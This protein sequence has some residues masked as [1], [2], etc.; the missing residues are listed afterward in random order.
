MIDSII[1]ILLLLAISSLGS[2]IYFYGTRPVPGTR[3]RR[4]F[5]TLWTTTPIGWV[6]MSQKLALLSVFSF[7][8]LTRFVGDFPGRDVIALVLY[9]AM[10]G[11]F[12]AV[13]IVLRIT[14]LPSEK[15]ERANPRRS[16][17]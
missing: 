15:R 3:F 5:S 7:I 16:K 1:L 4:R 9:G 6:L 10:V 8:L 14:Q 2:F 17:S 11:L 13:F 12:W